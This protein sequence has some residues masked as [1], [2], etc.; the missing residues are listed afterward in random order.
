MYDFDVLI[1]RKEYTDKQTLGELTV[2]Q[3]RV[4]PIYDCKTLELEEEKNAVRDDCIP[5]GIY[6]VVKRWSKKYGNHFHVLDVPNRSMILIHQANYHYQ[7]LGCIAV[8]EKHLD[9]NNDGYKDVTNSVNTMKKL[10]ELLPN[11]FVLKI[12]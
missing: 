3:D 9:I 11:E 10:N 2:Y 8:G 6:K 5:K 1:K 7:L 4:K 12:V